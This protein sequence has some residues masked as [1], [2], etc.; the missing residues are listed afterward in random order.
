MWGFIFGLIFLYKNSEYCDGLLRFFS[1]FLFEYN[2]KNIQRPHH[3]FTEIVLPIRE[4]KAF[5]IQ[6][7]FIRCASVF[8]EASASC[9]SKAL[10]LLIKIC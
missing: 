4:S 5:S 1:V 2:V 6:P 8:I 9:N 3:N 7:S 10:V